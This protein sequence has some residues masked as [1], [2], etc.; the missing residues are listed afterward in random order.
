MAVL[1]LLPVTELLK[2]TPISGSMLSVLVRVTSILALILFSASSG[3]NNDSLAMV[4]YGA[5]FGVTGIESSPL[6]GVNCAEQQNGKAV[7][8]NNRYLNPAHFII[9]KSSK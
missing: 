9:S 4:L 5:I 1:S 3:A 7:S 2:I 8:N 6:P